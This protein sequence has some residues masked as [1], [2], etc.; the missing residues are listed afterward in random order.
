MPT[1]VYVRT[2]EIRQKMKLSHQKGWVSTYKT[3][4]SE[5]T[6]SGIPREITKA[7]YGWTKWGGAKNGLEVTSPEWYCQACKE[8][9]S[10]GLPRYLI[11]IEGEDYGKI[12]SV[13]LHKAIQ[14]KSQNIFDL[15]KFLGRV[16]PDV[17]N[18]V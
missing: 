3:K 13:C 17:D 7:V 6:E 14:I 18:S 2:E 11:Q 1:G 8:K 16:I 15:I 4:R 9:Q 10:E 5:V 12:C